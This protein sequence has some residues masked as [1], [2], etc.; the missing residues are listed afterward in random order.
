MAQERVQKI[1]AQAGIASRRKAEEM[2]QEGLVTINGKLAK[3]GDKADLETDSIKVRGKLLHTKEAPVY[4]AVYKPKA[5]IS[6]L[7]DP[8][9]RPTLMD[10][11]GAKVK[12]RVYP[13]GRLDFMSEGLILM[14]ND[15]AFAE[16]LQKMEGVPRV[17]HIK[18]RGRPD[19]SMIG[20][21][22]KGARLGNRL[23]KPH[24]IRL[25]EE[26]ANK[27]RIEMVLTDSGAVDVKTLFEQKGFLV[28][29]IRR[30][31]IG[32][33]TLRGLEPGRFRF[34]KQSQVEA[35]LTHPELGLRTLSE[36]GRPQ[37]DGQ[38]FHYR[39]PHGERG[40]RPVENAAD[41]ASN[42]GSSASSV[43]AKPG[44]PR[45]RSVPIGGS[46][47][48]GLPK[49]KMAGASAYA[50][51][52]RSSDREF[53]KT[54]RATS[55]F[56]G[57]SRGLP[58]PRSASSEGLSGGSRGFPKPRGGAGAGASSS[59]RSGMGKKAGAGRSGGLPKPRGMSSEGAGSR[60]RSFEPRGR[61]RVTRKK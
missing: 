1:L 33:I 35:L 61:I 5:V 2:I 47:G 3:L 59:T 18:V 14:T 29:S 9:G 30:T 46:A 34:L 51:E 26:L 12:A 10:V 32:Q 20:R 7:S 49:P 44:L 40:E 54:R 38:G 50:G 15:G 41:A 19:A 57:G 36:E 6:A 21:L 22:E 42:S 37:A 45:P 25:A 48:R 55:N 27:V 53:P 8:E 28:E 52:G 39:R 16:K 24:S 4:L 23:V 56:G 13:I 11:L 60:T 17:Y 43:G 31:A 58:K